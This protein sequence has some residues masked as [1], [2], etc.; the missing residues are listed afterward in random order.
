M[1]KIILLSL[2]AMFAMQ[3]VV[4]AQTVRRFT[5]DQHFKSSNTKFNLTAE[6]E[7]IFRKMYE[8]ADAG[9]DSQLDDDT[10]K[11]TCIK[12]KK[13]FEANHL[14]DEQREA[15]AEKVAAAKAK[16]AAAN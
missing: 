10:Y 15:Y 8:E 16:R 4:T 12:L 11:K 1:R 3:L 6:Q 9:I 2:V 7:A 14:T 5:I 13:D